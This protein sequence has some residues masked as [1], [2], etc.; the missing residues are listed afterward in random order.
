MSRATI[1]TSLPDQLPKRAEFVCDVLFA[2]FYR[3]RLL[4]NSDYAGGD[5][6]EACSQRFSAAAG[7][8]CDWDQ[9][10]SESRDEISTSE[11]Q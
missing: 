3:I 4:P 6:S 9:S 1:R 2:A 8:I 10:R 7:F 5:L 11:R